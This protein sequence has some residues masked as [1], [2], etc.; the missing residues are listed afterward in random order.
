MFVRDL[1]LLAI[2]NVMFL[3]HPVLFFDIS[4]PS[5]KVNRLDQPQPYYKSKPFS[6]PGSLDFQAS[7]QLSDSC[8]Q[9]MGSVLDPEI[10]PLEDLQ[11]L[12]TQS[13]QRP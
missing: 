4:F 1:I 12:P 6:W 11:G 5:K 8:R 9:C 7:S 3:T 13:L 10:F 2:L